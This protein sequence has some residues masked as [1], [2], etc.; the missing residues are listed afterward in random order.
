[1][2]YKNRIDAGEKLA[3]YLSEYAGMDDAL[4]LALPRGGVPVASRVAEALDLPMD[5]FVVR[6][7]RTPG[8]EE[9]AM[10]AIAAGGVR[11]IN[12]AVADQMGLSDKQIAAA[13]AQEKQVLERTERMYRKDRGDIHL[14][15]RT[16]IVVDDGMAT[17]STM[18][19]VVLA[20]KALKPSEIIVA[21]PVASRQACNEMEYL[22]NRVVCPETPVPFTAVGKWYEDFSQTS[23]EEVISLMDKAKKP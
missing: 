10:G 6:K 1:M 11:I 16:A 18:R 7:L 9:L 12:E 5:V 19:A 14:T 13:A 22:V 4:V 15:D 21:V 3:G 17:G 8:H 23:D 20:L 2:I